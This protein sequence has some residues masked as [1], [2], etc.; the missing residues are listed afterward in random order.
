MIVLRAH[1]SLSVSGISIFYVH[2]FDLFFSIVDVQKKLVSPLFP[3]PPPPQHR[4]V[5]W[6]SARPG[7]ILSFKCWFFLY[8]FYFIENNIFSILQFVLSRDVSCRRPLILLKEKFSSTFTSRT[9]IGSSPSLY[10]RSNVHWTL[11]K[12]YRLIECWKSIFVSINSDFSLL[13][14]LFCYRIFPM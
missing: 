8:K 11:F 13:F 14:T 3:S 9:P 7:A 1:S 4:P 5:L 2:F 12:L 6:S 10:V